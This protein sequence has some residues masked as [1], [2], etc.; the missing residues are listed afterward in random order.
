MKR[1]VLGILNIIVGIFQI[2]YLL[3][4]NGTI[5]ISAFIEDYHYTDDFE[6]LMDVF[7]LIL[8]ATII[9]LLI[10]TAVSY[11]KRKKEN[12][13]NTGETLIIASHIISTIGFAFMGIGTI[14]SPLSIIGGIM[15]LSKSN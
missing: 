8:S 10:F 13:N 1:K 3:I 4:Q 12:L 6:K 7:M 5:K 2:V 15:L 11:F 14:L 9:V